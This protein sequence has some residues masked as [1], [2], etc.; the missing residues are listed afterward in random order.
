MGAE[1]YRIRPVGRE[2]AKAL[3][4]LHKKCFAKGWSH[5]EFESFFERA[6]V[7]AA[8]AN[9]AQQGAVGF[10]LCWIIEDQCDLLSMGVLEDFRRDGVGV[11]LLNYALD[12]AASLGAKAL[13]LEVNIH[14]T[15]AIALY[16]SHGFEQFSI[17]KDYYSNKDGTR[18]DAICM[19]KMLG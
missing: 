7:F 13:V 12:N 18:A 5:L 3:A 8:V 11:M 6:G 2:H 15:A 16:E 9:H 10:V 1:D 14:N 19:R 17:R 4:E